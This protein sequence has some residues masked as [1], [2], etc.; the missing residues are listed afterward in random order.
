MF[1][2][3]LLAEKIVSIHQSFYLPEGA[4]ESLT[5]Y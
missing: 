1:G 4:P 5:G 3:I 2:K